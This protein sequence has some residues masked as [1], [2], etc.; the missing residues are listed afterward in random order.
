MSKN[1]NKNTEKNLNLINNSNKLNKFNKQI[2]ITV[3]TT[4][5]EKLIKSI[6]E[7]SFYYFFDNLKFTKM[8]IQKGKGEYNPIKFLNI[9]LE[10]LI[11][12]VYDILPNFEDIIKESDYIISHGGAGIILESLKNKKKTFVVVN[13]T[14]MDNHQI[15]LAFS[16]EKDNYI[17]YVKYTE[18]IV[19]EVKDTITN[20][21]NK[22]WKVYPDFDYEIIPNLIYE[23][24]DL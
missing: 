1:K 9:K 24:L 8:I 20:I 14:L 7:E 4:K 18:D 13:D 10:N 6:D 3:G 19:N 22:N 5:F 2:L 12:E 11:V 15:E 17:F 21:D 16:L 23:M